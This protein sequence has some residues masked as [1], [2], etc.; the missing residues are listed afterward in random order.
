MLFKIILTLRPFLINSLIL[1]YLTQEIA[2]TFKRFNSRS[3]T[4]SVCILTGRTIGV[5][6]KNFRVNRMQVK[7]KSL[8]GYFPGVRKSS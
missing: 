2:L 1:R 8:Q 6:R 7:E 5:Y 3:R 4:R